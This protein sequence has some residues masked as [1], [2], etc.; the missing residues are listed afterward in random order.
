MFSSSVRKL[1]QSGESASSASTRKLVQWDDNQ[2]EK[3]RL[4]FHKMQISDRRY[5]ENVFKNLRQKFNLANVLIWRF[6]DVDND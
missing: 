3:T 2:V 6:I 4:E 1:V 5:L